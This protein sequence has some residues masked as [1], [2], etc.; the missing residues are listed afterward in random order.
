MTLCSVS[1]MT[2][3]PIDPLQYKNQQRQ[4]WG[5]VAAGWKQWWRTIERGAQP[6]SDRLVALSGLQ[7]GHHVLDVATGIGEPAVTAVMKVGPTG[8]VV[9]IDQATEML[10]IARE[11]M[12]E[13]GLKNL[14][15]REMDAEALDLNEGSFDTILC[16]WGLMFLPNLSAALTKMHQLLKPGGR[17]AAAVWG[18]PPEV[19]MISVAMG[20]VS[21]ALQVPPPS[22]QMP[23]P[24]SLADSARL[25]SAF[26]EAGFRNIKTEGLTITL[27]WASPEEYTRFQQTVAA[28]IIA[29]LANEP[30]ARQQQVWQ[31]V[32]GAARQYA[33]ARGCVR[34]T[35]QVLCVVASR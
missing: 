25:E 27:E 16:R 26:R 33:D 2:N 1:F 28:P 30:P 11:R 34:M 9:A 17:L 13:L 5:S 7:P 14:I 10:D 21:K 20:T 3:Q 23:G 31:A 22:P 32:T 15:L 19:P 24:F 12:A 4:A 18:P 8:R 6:V 29:L 35:N